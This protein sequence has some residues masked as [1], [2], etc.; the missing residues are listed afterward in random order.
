MN[1][2][3]FL[4]YEEIDNLYQGNLLKDLWVRTSSRLIEMSSADYLTT[5]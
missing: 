5:N 4:K 2:K 3:L 1:I